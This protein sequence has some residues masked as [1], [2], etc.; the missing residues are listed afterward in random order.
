MQ[1]VVLVG[2]TVYS[3]WA[4]SSGVIVASHREY[5]ESESIRQMIMDTEKQIHEKEEAS[6]NYLRRDRL[7]VLRKNQVESDRLKPN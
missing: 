5:R 1:R 2:M 3:L 4:I 6:E 7:S